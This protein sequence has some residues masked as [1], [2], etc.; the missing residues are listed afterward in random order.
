[1]LNSHV[2]CTQGEGKVNGYISEGQMVS[3]AEK[4]ASKQTITQPTYPDLGRLQ[5]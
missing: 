3:M 2:L 4:K 5:I 1:M